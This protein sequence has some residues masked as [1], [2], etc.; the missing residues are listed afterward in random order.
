MPHYCPPQQ[1]Q[2]G[3]FDLF[4]LSVAEEDADILIFTQR[5]G[6]QER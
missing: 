6:K 2:L 5:E 4:D 3:D 1:I